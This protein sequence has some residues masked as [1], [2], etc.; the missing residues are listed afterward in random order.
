MGKM[1]RI[2]KIIVIGLLSL[3]V[4]STVGLFIF[5]KTFNV[6]RFKPQ[7]ISA[8]QNA[9]SRSVNFGDIALKIS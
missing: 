4:I 3:F 7:I 5:L 8:A 9:L 1:K 6:S 2:F